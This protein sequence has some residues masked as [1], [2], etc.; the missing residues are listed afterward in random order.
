MSVHSSVGETRPSYADEDHARLGDELARLYEARDADPGQAAEVAAEIAALRARLRRGPRL[1]AG[2]F[3]GD[4][5]YRLLHVLQ[6]AGADG[7]WKAWDRVSEQLVEVRVFHGA[8]VSDEVAIRQFLE[9]GHRLTALDHPHIGRVLEVGR[10]EEGFVFMVTRLLEGV[11]LDEP[12][13]L[14]RD[15]ALHPLDAVQ[16]LVEVGRALQAAHDAGVVHGD[17]RPDHVLVSPAGHAWVTGF[18]VTPGLERPPAAGSLYQAP[19]SADRATAPGPQGDVYA[20]GMTVMFVLNGGELPFWVLRDPQRLLGSLPVGEGVREVLGRAI[21]WD[22]DARFDDVTA[23]LEALLADL[24]LVE[25][26]AERA[27]A[28]GR[29]GE[30]ARHYEELLALQ[31]H[32]EVELRRLLGEQYTAAGQDGPAFDHLAAALAVSPRAAEL[33]GP[34]REIAARTDGWPQLTEALA[35]HLEARDDANRSAMRVELATLLEHQR[36]DL[37]GAGEAWAAVYEDHRTPA[38]AE[39]AL[40]ALR[41]IAE[42][43]QDWSSYV[44][45]SE[46][47]LD[48]VTDDERA[49]IEYSIGLA[50]LEHLDRE[51]LGLQYIDRAESH[52][53]TEVELTTRLQQV[54]AQM[55]QWQRVI[56]LMM[57]QAESQ[58]IAQASPTLMRAGIIANAVHLEEEAFAVYHALLQRAPRHVVALR[59]L[60]RMH[61]RAHEYENATVYYERL[62][63]TYRGKLSEEPEASERAADCLAYAQLLLR[64][65]RPREATERLDEAMR[66]APDHVPTLELA[67]P[68]FL[69]LGELKKAGSVYERLLALFKSVERSPQKIAA[70]LGMGELCWLQGR[71]TAAMGWYNRAIELDPFSVAGWWGLSKVALTAR[72][73]HPGTERAPWIRAMPKRFAPEEALARLLAGLLSP[74]SMRT[75]LQSSV[76]GATLTEG[77]ALPV[78]L[79]CGVV[80]VM[81]RNEVV[82]PEL[83]ERL[84]AACPDWAEPI[85]AVRDLFFGDAAPGFSVAQTYPWSSRLIE[86]DF[87]ATEVRS[88][89]PPQRP[90]VPVAQ[91]ELGAPT[92][93]EVLL[94]DAQPPPPAPFVAP[95]ELEARKRAQLA[96]PVV[97]LGQAGLLWGALDRTSAALSIGA[98]DDR[99]VAI[100]EDEAVQPEHAVLRR[101]GREVYVE[102]APGAPTAVN[103]VGVEGPWRLRAGDALTVGETTLEVALHES[104]DTLPA[105]RREPP[106]VARAADVAELQ[107]LLE[108][109]EEGGEGAERPPPVA[110]E[111]EVDLSAPPPPAADPG[112]EAEAEAGGEIDPFGDGPATEPMAERSQELAVVAAD[113]ELSLAGPPRLDAA[114]GSRPAQPPE[115]LQDALE[116]PEEHRAD[117]LL[118]VDDDLEH[119]ATESGSPTPS[120]P[121]LPTGSEAPPPLPSASA[122]AHGLASGVW[123][124]VEFMSGPR[125]GETVAIGDQLTVG[126]AEGSGVSVPN[127]AR[128]SPTHCVVERT[129]DG[130]RLRDAGSATGTVV[131]GKR[132][133]QLMLRGGE[134]IMVGRTVLRFRQED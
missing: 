28:R 46:P 73:G 65:G 9:R 6:R 52:G 44:Q 59:H 90:E 130:F 64:D 76:M 7:F 98:A 84:Q 25:A 57:H 122:S 113:E 94:A 70:C 100:P 127:D 66:V 4:G 16:L 33:F 45:Y 101:V 1:L 26:L 32:R 18:T 96:G 88:V 110:V 53:W 56:Q 43:L 120:P 92:S 79:A 102:P 129:A 55:G 93:W 39:Q 35:R 97:S 86:Q 80:D 103:G 82:S 128:L 3:L 71:V 36:G 30:A 111:Q 8:W 47:L 125:R 34:L 23:L 133:E 78:R 118:P 2:E 15:G 112:P 83:F 60:A 114:L 75:W 87:D 117:D 108:T 67:G 105:E 63:E 17:L 68:L 58:D 132:I 119:E 37:P 134:T 89:L 104:E 99:D 48:Y 121:P 21:D 123:A 31:P 124:Y 95:E 42:E 24:Q 131:N 40:R 69:G 77:G 41:A 12:G 5:R 91:A 109:G 107:A 20:L 62:W 49:G 74:R 54:R 81:Q 13:A 38:Q 126:Q 116:A 11:T 29:P 106:R 19:E 22:L 51:E 27:Q 61:H 115:W 72:A 50:Y 14:H 85:S 10:S